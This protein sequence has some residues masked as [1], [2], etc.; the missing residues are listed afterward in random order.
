METTIENQ[1]QN[2]VTKLLQ[3]CYMNKRESNP[4]YSLRAFAKTLQIDQAYLIRVLKGARSPSPQ[5]AYKISQHL[6]F[7]HEETLQLIVKTFK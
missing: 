1:Q 7:S 5:I 4:A 2:E 3:Q 6:K